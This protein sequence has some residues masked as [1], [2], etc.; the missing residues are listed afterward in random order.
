MCKVAY[1]LLWFMLG[2][3]LTFSL[4]CATVEHTKIGVCG[5][6]DGVRYNVEYTLEY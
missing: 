2:L 6:Q 5:V 3:A 1:I 4:G